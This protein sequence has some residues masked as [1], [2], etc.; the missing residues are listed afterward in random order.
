MNLA[1]DQLATA[2]FQKKSFRDCS[3][4]ELESLSKDY[5]YFAPLSLLQTAKLQ[6]LNSLDFDKQL[7][8]TSLYFPNPLMLDVLLFGKGEGNIEKKE[9]EEYGEHC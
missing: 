1:L 8:H 6:D 3:L 2:V 9:I 5:P 4:D 7:Q